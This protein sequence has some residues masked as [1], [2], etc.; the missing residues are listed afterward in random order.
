MI[1]EDYCSFEIAKLLNEKGFDGGCTCLIEDYKP[2]YI[3]RTTWPQTYKD[4]GSYFHLKGIILDPTHQMALKWLREVHG[5]FINLDF[6]LANGEK[7]I[8]WS[9]V[10]RNNSDVEFL[11]D[12]EFEDTYEQ[13]VEAALL[14]TLKK[15]DMLNKALE[16]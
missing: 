8:V 3:L 15:L 5:L 16:E 6:C 13:A 11:S 7:G 1:T 10:R 9:V 14:Y 2:H 12:Y 4:D